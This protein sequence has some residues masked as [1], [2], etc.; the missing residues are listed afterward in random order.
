[1]FLTREQ[2]IAAQDRRFAEVHVPEWNGQVR[3]ASLDADAA[4]KYDALNRKRDA[5]DL[6]ANPLTFVV[7]RSIV[8]ANGCE[9][10]TDRDMEQLGK[11]SPAVLARLI[12]EVKK[13]N[14]MEVTPSGN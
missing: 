4:L 12:M 7:A 11:K 2:I 6:S 5:G 14:E 8:D 1:M 9:V 13:L 10:F 3:L